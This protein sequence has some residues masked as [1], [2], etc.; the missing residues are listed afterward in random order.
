MSKSDAEVIALFNEQVNMS[1][2]ELEEWLER[3]ESKKAGTGV[4]LESGARI[5]EIL[6]SNPNRDPDAYTEVSNTHV[7]SDAINLVITF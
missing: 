3:P 1:S 4:G 5:V 6:R 2:D 7:V